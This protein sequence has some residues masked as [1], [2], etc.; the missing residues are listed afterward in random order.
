MGVS[1]PGKLKLKNEG[2]RDQQSIVINALNLA[3]YSV[4]PISKGLLEVK[5]VFKQ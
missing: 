4:K 1:E 3:A 2:E 5:K